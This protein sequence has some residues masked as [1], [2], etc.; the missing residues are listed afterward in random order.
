MSSRRKWKS[1]QPARSGNF[2]QVVKLAAREPAAGRWATPSRHGLCCNFFL[3]SQKDGTMLF[4]H[5]DAE[6]AQPMQLSMRIWGTCSGFVRKDGLLCLVE[7][8]DYR[9]RPCQLT[10]HTIDP[11]TGQTISSEQRHFWTFDSHVGNRVF[12]AASHWAVAATD[13][14][15]LVIMEADTMQEVSRF[16]VTPR[17]AELDPITL[18]QGK[19][20]HT[21][22]KCWLSHLRIQSSN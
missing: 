18:R 19:L 3:S 22:G 15:S 6:G 12:N 17:H 13:H 9:T 1:Q 14:H 8:S 5:A 2:Q 7:A 16:T 4:L 10:W 11:A 20:D 21:M